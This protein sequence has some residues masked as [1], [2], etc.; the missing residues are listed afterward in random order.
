MA[1]IPMSLV[2]TAS[3]NNSFCNTAALS[4]M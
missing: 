4:K 3:Q 1:D 2:H